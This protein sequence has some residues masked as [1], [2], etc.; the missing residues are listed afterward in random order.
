[1]SIPRKDL[2]KLEL[3]DEVRDHLEAIIKLHIEIKKHEKGLMLGDWFNLKDFC[4][5]ACPDLADLYQQANTI[6][7]WEQ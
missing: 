4:L 7:G 6:C 2:V 3:R 1:M 5:N